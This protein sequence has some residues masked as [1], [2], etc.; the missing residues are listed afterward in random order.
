MRENRRF[1][2]Y[3]IEVEVE[4]VVPRPLRDHKRLMRTRDMSHGGLFIATD[5]DPL[6]PMGSELRVRVIREESAAEEPMPVVR[7]R[8]VRVSDEGMAVAFQDT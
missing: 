4:V 8:V 7:A 5:G 2:R 3:P 6:P 1:E